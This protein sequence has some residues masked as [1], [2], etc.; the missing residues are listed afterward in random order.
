ML[1]KIRNKIN[2]VL[3]DLWSIKKSIILN[4]LAFFTITFIIVKTLMWVLDIYTHHNESID[5]PNIVGMKIE[6][7][8]KLLEARKLNYIITDSIC[9]GKGL[10]GI[11]KQQNPL[12]SKKVKESRKIY[13]T[14][15]SFNECSVNLYYDRL[16]G[17]DREYVIR[18]LKRSN[19]EIGKLTYVN[20]GK[21]KNTVTEVFANGKPLFIEVSAKQGKKPPKEPRKVPQNSV[22]DL[23]LLRGIDDNP[24]FVPDLVC[25]KF[26]AAEFSI[27]SSQFNMGNIQITGNLKDTSEAW[28]YNQNPS[29]G[30]LSTMGAGINLWLMEAYPEGCKENDEEDLYD[31]EL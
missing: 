24:K 30:D 9:K 28:V 20:G 23:V 27:L 15:T 6:N 17:K 11:I 22:I 14:I 3:S 19:L 26:A 10:G 21:A 2:I 31:D 5:T 8:K 16:I 4:I 7:A 18:Y 1:E 13:L 12:P 29:P 25:K